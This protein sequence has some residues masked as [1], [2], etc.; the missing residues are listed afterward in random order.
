MITSQIISL[1]NSEI[2]RPGAEKISAPEPVFTVR[3]YDR[4][5]Q[6]T[7]KSGCPG[8]PPKHAVVVGTRRVTNEPGIDAID[9]PFTK[10]IH[11]SEVCGEGSAIVYQKSIV[12]E[13]ELAEASICKEFLHAP[14]VGPR[15]VRRKETGVCRPYLLRHFDRC[16]QGAKEGKYAHPALGIQVVKVVARFLR[17]AAME[18]NSLAQGRSAAIVQIG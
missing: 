13:P 9:R 3:F 17:F 12:T 8:V 11:R 2:L 15:Q 14:Q 16:P 6:I 18:E 4:D 5:G 1:Q 7:L 10:L